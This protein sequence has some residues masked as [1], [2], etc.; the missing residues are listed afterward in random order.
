LR[1]DKLLLFP[2]LENSQKPSSAIEVL[3]Q[4]VFFQKKSRFLKGKLNLLRMFEEHLNFQTSIYQNS[5]I[6]FVFG[7]HQKLS[8]Y[9]FFAET[10]NP[11]SMPPNF[12][13]QKFQKWPSGCPEN[14][15]IIEM[16]SDPTR[17]YLWP[18]VNKGPTHLWPGYFLTQPDDIFFDPKGKNC[19]IWDF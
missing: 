13:C 11:D 4:R 18:T 17:K 10:W 19:K 7:H 3:V 9:A 5:L 15:K 14:F 8:R 1:L 16:G 12:F 2:L 6:T